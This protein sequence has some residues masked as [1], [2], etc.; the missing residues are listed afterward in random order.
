MAE[1]NEAFIISACR[2]A[3]GNLHGGLGSLTAPQMGAL[4]VKEAVKR[5]D[6]III[7]EDLPL[8]DGWEACHQLRQTFGIPVVLFGD[9]YDVDVWLRVLQVGADF[10]LRMPFSSLE[11]A[12][13]ARAIIRRCRE[14]CPAS[15]GE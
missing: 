4:A 2:T 13:R 3:I 9:D 11:L 8:L 7:D 15:P 1:R 12:A 6:L 14:R 10:Y 5:G